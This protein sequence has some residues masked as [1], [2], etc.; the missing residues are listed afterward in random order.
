MLT[1]V[2]VV[3]DGKAKEMS[4]RIGLVN[5][6][7]SL[8]RLLVV[9]IIF[10]AKPQSKSNLCGLTPSVVIERYEVNNK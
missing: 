1:R 4:I 3:T 7:K 10:K 2:M 9:P 6:I 5:S 8:E